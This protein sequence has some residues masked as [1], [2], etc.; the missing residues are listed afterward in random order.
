MLRSLYGTSTTMPRAVTCIFCRGARTHDTSRL[1]HEMCPAA[2][3]RRRDRNAKWMR[4]QR[5][6]WIV[7]QDQTLARRA[8]RVEQRLAAH[9]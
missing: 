8:R 4:D 6:N 1:K 7:N 9:V 3:A 2:Y 5:S